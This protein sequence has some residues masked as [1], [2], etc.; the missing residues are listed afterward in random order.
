VIVDRA[1]PLIDGQLRALGR[2]A[3]VGLTSRWPWN[4]G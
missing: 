4:A 3:E 1:R 2:L